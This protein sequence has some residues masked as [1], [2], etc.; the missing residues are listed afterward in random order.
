MIGGMNPY[1][2]PRG[3]PNLDFDCFDLSLPSW[4]NL[5]LRRTE[6]WE[7]RFQSN[8]KTPAPFSG[9]IN[10]NY[11][12]V[13]LCQRCPC[14]SRHLPSLVIPPAWWTIKIDLPV[15]TRFRCTSH[16]KK[17]TP[18]RTKK[19]FWVI[20]LSASF[21]MLQWRYHHPYLSENV[22]K[23]LLIYDMNE[24]QKQLFSWSL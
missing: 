19:T 7:T 15:I 20:L 23:V 2:D 9:P 13:C 3:S 6:I 8:K 24:R 18:L 5:T 1:F 4:V 16:E 17:P 12:D 14:Y 11:S 22:V 21:A 10:Y